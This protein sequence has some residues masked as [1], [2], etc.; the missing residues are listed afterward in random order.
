M[1]PYFVTE[2]MAN[3]KHRYILWLMNFLVGGDHTAG[4]RNI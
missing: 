1:I 2:N 4:N 3:S